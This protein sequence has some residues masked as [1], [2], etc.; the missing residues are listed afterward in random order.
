MSTGAAILVPFAT[1]RLPLRVLRCLRARWGRL[2][3]Y[4]S[5]EFQE[6]RSSAYCETFNPTVQQTDAEVLKALLD[7][8]KRRD[9]ELLL[10]VTTKGFQFVS[11]HR[12]PLGSRFS[13]PPLA[14]LESLR[15][16]SD[17]GKLHG[18]MLHRGLPVLPAAPYAQPV[19]DDLRAGRRSLPFPVLVKPVNR[20]NGVGIRK[21]ACVAELEDDFR[22]T[23]HSRACEALIQRFVDGEDYSFA[24]LC[25]SGEIKAYACWKGLVASRTPYT[26][27]TCIEFVEN[28]AVFGICQRLMR[29]LSWEGVCDIDIIYDPSSQEVWILEIN[30]RFWGNVIACERGGVNFPELMIRCG[31]GDRP[32]TW[33]R[34]KTGTIFCYARGVAQALREPRIRSALL[35]QPFRSTALGSVLRDPCPE[36]CRIGWKLRR[37]KPYG[38]D[39]R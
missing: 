22:R 18:F 20:E 9:R 34:Q 8:P 39:R 10:P 15:I 17:K 38:V 27:P 35:R 19:L 28:D 23:A 21:I 30:A 3:L 5:D 4:S 12:E 6:A 11:E 16:A 1:G 32:A 7:V 25:E 13:I 36:L 26:I 14:S 37:A 31:L 2:H 33:P 29:A 24:C